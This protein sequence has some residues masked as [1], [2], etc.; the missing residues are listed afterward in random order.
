MAHA[1]NKMGMSK[2]QKAYGIAGRH[3]AGESIEELAKAYGIKPAT[4]P[5]YIR[6]GQQLREDKA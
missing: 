2:R 6:L 5:E 3:A 1:R 4:V